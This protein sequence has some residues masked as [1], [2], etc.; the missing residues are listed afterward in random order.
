MKLKPALGVFLVFVVG[1][2][3]ESGGNGA[4]DTVRLAVLRNFGMLGR[5][6]PM[7]CDS[8]RM[9]CVIRRFARR[10]PSQQGSV[11]NWSLRRCEER[12]Q[13][14][15][16][17]ERMEV[18]KRA[19]ASLGEEGERYAKALPVAESR[20]PAVPSRRGSGGVG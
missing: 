14:A 7:S 3:G 1:V 9:N 2:A 20:R 15:E 11:F 12:P 13:Q 16:G 17:Y 18:V 6:R 4:S 8:C 10:M 5:L 19:F